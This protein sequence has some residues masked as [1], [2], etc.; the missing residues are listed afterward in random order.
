MKR[1]SQCRYPVVMMLPITPNDGQAQPYLKLI[2]SSI[3][4]SRSKRSVSTIVLQCTSGSCSR[5]LAQLLCNVFARDRKSFPLW[6][7]GP[8]RGVGLLYL[9]FASSN[10]C[11]ESHTLTSRHVCYVLLVSSNPPPPQPT[12]PAVLL[13]SSYRSSASAG[14]VESPSRACH[15]DVCNEH[16][17]DPGPWCII[18]I[19]HMYHCAA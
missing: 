5:I 13:S 15:T 9:L 11:S 1:R 8:I 7:L 19:F 12:T 16:F 3:K 2:H 6:R 14:N 18:P 17:E 4:R 10:I